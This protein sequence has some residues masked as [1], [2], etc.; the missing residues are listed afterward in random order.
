MSEPRKVDPKMVLFP[1][2]VS[3][4]AGGEKKSGL[5][6]V[7]G[8]LW[9]KEGVFV[10]R[11]YM[12]VNPAT[13]N[14]AVS[15]GKM[16]GASTPRGYKTK[17]P[18]FT[19]EDE[20]NVISRMIALRQDTPEEDKK[21]IQPFKKRLEALRSNAK[22]KSFVEA[23]LALIP[24]SDYEIE[25]EEPV[26]SDSGAVPVAAQETE[27]DVNRLVETYFRKVEE[28]RKT[29]RAILNEA[30]LDDLEEEKEVPFD[31]TRFAKAWKALPPKWQRDPILRKE[32]YG[33]ADVKEQED[34]ETRLRKEKERLD[35]IAET[36]EKKRLEGLEVERRRKEEQ[37]KKGLVDEEEIR[38]RYLA[39][40]KS[41]KKAVYEDDE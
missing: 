21:Y 6:D 17:A 2:P 33:D 22:M 39:E 3:Y 28:E 15:L 24:K 31:E 23:N 37:K 27:E 13:G 32:F 18:F 35:E 20:P 41:G 26:R 34:T 11:L 1:K 38:K 4:T 14:L 19:D 5:F 30:T 12:V 16:S 10:K 9:T 25:E 40:R 36:L 7:Y 29:Y 8:N